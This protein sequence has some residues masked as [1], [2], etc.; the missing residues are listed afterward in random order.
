MKRLLTYL[1]IVVLIAGAVLGGYFL[2]QG[3]Q[4]SQASTT[5]TYQQVVLATRGDITSSLSV[6]GELAAVQQADLAFETLS[7]VTSLATMNV[8]PGHVVKAGDVLA[9]IDPESYQQA[10]EQAGSDL[11]AAEQ[12]L[13]ELEEPVTAVAI[14]QADLAIAKAEYDISNAQATLDELLDPDIEQ[15]KTDVADA[16]TAIAEAQI[17]LL[18]AQQTLNDTPSSD[19]MEKLLD[20]EG[21]RAEVYYRLLNETY[22]DDYYEDRLTVAFNQMM[23]AKEARIKAEMQPQV[24][25]LNAKIN[26]RKAE[27]ALAS[28]EEAL[29]DALNGADS[30][31]TARAKVTLNAGIVALAQSREARAE[32]DGGPDATDLAAAKADVDAKKLALADA[33]AAL[34]ATSLAAPFDGT[35]LQVDANAGDRISSG[36]TILTIADL[37]GLEVLASVDETTI[38]SVTAGQAAQITF[39]AL[40]GQTLSGVVGSIPL[41]GTLQGDVMVYEVPV[42][43]QG[44]QNLSLMVGMTAN[45][46]IATGEAAGALLV[47]AMALTRSGGMYQVQVLDSTSPDAVPQSVPVQIGLSNGTYTQITAGVNEGDRVVV[48]LSGSDSAASQNQPGGGGLLGGGLMGMFGRR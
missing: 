19:S 40:P 38:K 41:Q 5:E 45:V 3:R 6:V 23:E 26:V 44:A 9:T 29:A 36:T 7:G 11:T 37:T 24:D 39:D 42:S 27:Q 13:A 34:A 30:V 2:L 33:Q 4:T 32:L 20:T 8:A 46:S 16:K 43:L 12:T 10:V 15:L 35:I 31:E 17:D 47:P 48:Q 14:A 22:R 25:V 1:G 21:D 18:T 28:A